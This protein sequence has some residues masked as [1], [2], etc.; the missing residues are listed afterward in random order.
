MSYSGFRYIII[1]LWNV[2][3]DNLLPTC[4][5]CPGFYP[6]PPVFPHL[7][8]FPL[9]LSLSSPPTHPFPLFLPSS[10]SPFF[11]L[12]ALSTFFS[13]GLIFCHLGVRDPRSFVVI[14]H[15]LR[16]A[17]EVGMTSTI[18]L[19]VE[20]VSSSSSGHKGE[21]RKEERREEGGRREEGNEKT[22][23]WY[24]LRLRT[25]MWVDAC[26]STCMLGC[27]DD[28]LLWGI[29]VCDRRCIVSKET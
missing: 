28:K 2:G 22:Q 7:P 12:L 18:A 25:L 13:L 10:L 24:N 15:R 29:V 19:D 5:S 6:T 4:L 20:K 11:S 9:S 21:R 1:S 16:L 14:C 23:W 3:N 8:L 17:K 26:Y 27:H